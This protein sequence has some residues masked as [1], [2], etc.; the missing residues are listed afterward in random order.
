VDKKLGFYSLRAEGGVVTLF[1]KALPVHHMKTSVAK[2]IGLQM[3]GRLP[4]LV[5][6]VFVVPSFCTLFFD[7]GGNSVARVTFSETR[8]NAMAEFLAG[9]SAPVSFKVNDI[10]ETDFAP[11]F[12]PVGFVIEHDERSVTAQFETAYPTEPITFALQPN[13]FYQAGARVLRH[14]TGAFKHYG[15]SV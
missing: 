8:W 7:H 6:G 2:W 3:Q 1:N 12:T 10:V 14:A 9:L 15:R 4:A 5:D 13:G 11:D